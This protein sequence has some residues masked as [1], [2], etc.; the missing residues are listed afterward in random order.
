[1]KKNIYLLLTFLGLLF[2]YYFIF[3]FYIIDTTPTLQAI[4]G[5]FATNMS[6]AFNSD[7]L[8]SV[9]TAWVFMGFEGKRI[10]MKNW[11]LFLPATLI[12]LSFALP[13]FLY[14]R[15]RHLENKK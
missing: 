5:L 3:Q 9:L 10:N 4:T 11:W 15:E 12:G 14:F 1:M 6:A 13:L 2:P 8:M 7:L